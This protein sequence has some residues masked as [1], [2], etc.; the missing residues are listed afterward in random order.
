MLA[1]IGLALA[2]RRIDPS[3]FRVSLLTILSA[4][5]VLYVLVSGLKWFQE[6][7]LAIGYWGVDDVK[8]GTDLKTSVTINAEL[9]AALSCAMFVDSFKL[10]GRDIKRYFWLLPIAVALYVAI[11]SN[12]L[13]AILLICAAILLTLVTLA[14]QYRARIP[15][16]LAIVLTLI[17]AIAIFVASSL[18]I[19][20]SN[21]KRMVSN[22]SLAVD[23]DEDPDVYS[24]MVGRLAQLAL[25]DALAVAVALKRG[26]ELQ[27]TLRRAKETLVAKRKKEGDM[28]TPLTLAA[29]SR[30]I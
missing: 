7:H 27:E 26:P 9:L 29:R 25:V 19:V 13:N 16:A 20:N 22:V 18:P 5:A 6:G 4:Q 21:I 14:Y 28:L 12:S 11:F 15:R 24:P 3:V 10:N 1:G 17:I 23:V 2:S 8:L 30:W